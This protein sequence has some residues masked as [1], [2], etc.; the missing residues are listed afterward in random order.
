MKIVKVDCIA[1]SIP[2]NPRPAAAV[3]DP[4][5][6]IGAAWNM[7]DTVLVRVETDSGIVGWGEAFSYHCRQAVQAA[8]EHMVAP[9]VIGRDASDINALMYELQRKLHL[10]GRYGITMFALSGLDIALWDI[11]AKAAGMPLYRLLGGAPRKLD[12]YASLFFIADPEIVAAHCQAA[13][14]QG[15]RYIKLHETGEAQVRAARQAL[16]EGVPLMVDTN[17]PWT[18]DEA[19]L[20][21]LAL[22]PYD[23]HW[24]EEPIFPPEDF[25]ALG[26]LQRE[27]GVP[28]ASGEN[29]C[30][31]FQFREMFAHQA[32]RYAQPSVTKVGG[33]SEFRK[34]QALAEAS[35]V[36]VMPHA[37]YFGPG[38]LATLHLLAASAKPG[39]V[40]RFYVAL[41]AGL[42][43]AA[44]DPAGGCFEPPEGPG[45]GIEPDADVIRTYRV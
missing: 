2:F 43:G 44:T 12:A 39:L 36:R 28:L 27:T 21:A 11:A 23:L 16:G 19:R 34:V 9:L 18:P 20:M 41:E 7:L 26:R 45:L 5:S 17:C 30:T 32:V 42:Y 6:G 13:L 33:V 15:Y 10:W 37:P 25:L 4:P 38:F 31:S 29:A 22:R 3:S 14:A 40:E 8:V 35:A 24:L 1:V